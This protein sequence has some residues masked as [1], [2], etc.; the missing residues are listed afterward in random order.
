MGLKKHKKHKSERLDKID[1]NYC[2]LFAVLTSSM[3]CNP[4]ND[5]LAQYIKTPAFLRVVYYI[6]VFLFCKFLEST[7]GEKPPALKIILKVGGN[8]ST[9]EHSNDSVPSVFG[10]PQ[11]S[12]RSM[13][14]TEEESLS[15]ASV[16]SGSHGD[17][18]KKL[19]KKKKKKE[20]EKNKEKHEKKHKHRHKVIN[21]KL[22]FPFDHKLI[23]LFVFC[24]KK[25][26]DHMM[27]LLWMTTASVKIQL[28]K[29]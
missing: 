26:N 25:G 16:T 14:Q 18:H 13:P 24:R 6:F 5:A 10:T 22:S 17:R 27:N 12:M 1:G 8:L 9:P 7:S 19:K 23:K 4:N 3:C 21:I 29:L 11:G 15:L 28:Q 20:R 2:V